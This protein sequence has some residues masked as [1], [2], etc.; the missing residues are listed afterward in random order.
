MK[1]INWN[2]NKLID[3]LQHIHGRKMIVTIVLCGK[4][5]TFLQKKG[6]SFKRK[7]FS[8][9]ER[10]F[11]QK[12]GLFFKGKDFSSNER[13]FLQKKGKV[14]PSKDTQLLFLQETPYIVIHCTN[15]SCRNHFVLFINRCKT[16]KKSEKPFR[17]CYLVKSTE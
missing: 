12:K 15:F 9:N 17:S 14:L 2:I 7:D 5:R 16:M 1:C 11:L 8:P 10:I 6:L 13:S 3:L 4:G